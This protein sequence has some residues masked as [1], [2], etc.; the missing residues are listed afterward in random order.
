M[1]KKYK[2]IFPYIIVVL[3]IPLLLYVLIDLLEFDVNNISDSIWLSFWGTYIGA[4]LGSLATMLGVIFTIQ[5]NEKIHEEEN[6]KYQQD[7][8]RQYYPFLIVNTLSESEKNSVLPT[9]PVE[10]ICRFAFLPEEKIEL[11][12]FRKHHSQILLKL[13]NIGVGPALNVQIFYNSDGYMI[14]GYNDRKVEG[15]YNKTSIELAK[16]EEKII[17]FKICFSDSLIKEMPYLAK[18]LTF[19][20]VYED[21]LSNK[22]KKAISLSFEYQSIMGWDKQEYIC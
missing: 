2:V 19:E 20:I 8:I 18:A 16:D 11:S 12:K 13:K 15:M 4:I 9:C 21:I 17:E 14:D 10:K 6:K 5:E 7:V 22:I 3:V 1:N